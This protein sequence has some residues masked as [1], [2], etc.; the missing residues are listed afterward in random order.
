MILFVCSLTPHSLGQKNVVVLIYIDF[1]K[2]FDMVSPGKLLGKLQRKRC[3]EQLLNCHGI[4]CRG[5]ENGL[6]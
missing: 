5:D 3:M 1:I 4:G 6:G 2:L